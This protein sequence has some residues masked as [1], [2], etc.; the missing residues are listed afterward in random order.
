MRIAGSTKKKRRGKE[1]RERALALI[2][3]GLSSPLFLAC[4]ALIEA[5]G[6]LRRDARGPVFF[7]ERRMSRGE[8]FDLLKFRTLTAS[9]LA[10]LDEGPTHIAVLEKSGHLTIA[11]RWIRQWYLDELPQLINI[12]RG[13]MGLVGTRPWP[14]ELYEEELAKG[15]TRKRDM[16]SGLVGP[17][18]S[19]K[20][21]AGKDGLT[22]DAE[23]WEAYQTYSGWKLLLLDLKI[24]KRSLK[25]QL[26]HKG[27]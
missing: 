9:A 15:I 8:P 13:E 3:V 2:L 17:V 4:A 26:E 20:G 11:G 22:L 16:P 21:H 6:L 14:I 7:R 23:Y 24:I 5:E 19:E 12:V 10:Q 27:I 25:V 1:M 18:Q